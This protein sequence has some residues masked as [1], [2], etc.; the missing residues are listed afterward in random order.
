MNWRSWKFPAQNT[1][2]YEVGAL[3]PAGGGD[4]RGAGEYGETHGSGGHGVHVHRHPVVCDHCAQ[5][6]KH[7]QQ[8]SRA[9]ETGASASEQ[10]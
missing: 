1:T 3:R 5:Q 8:H 9:A 4:E 10:R 6:G 2:G 7:H